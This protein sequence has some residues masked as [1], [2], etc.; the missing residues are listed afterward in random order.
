MSATFALRCAPLLFALT[1]FFLTLWRF[2]AN[3]TAIL[4]VVLVLAYR[5]WRQQLFSKCYLRQ[6]LFLAIYALI[7][8]A[9]LSVSYAHVPH[10]TTAFQGLSVYL[11]LLFL[12]V[13]P[14]A[15]QNQKNRYW[16]EE[17]LI[18][19]VLVNV[20]L[21]SLHYFHLPLPAILDPAF[22]AGLNKT[23]AINALQLI[24]VVAL[25]LW[26][27]AS[28]VL[29][30]E[31]KIYDWIFLIVL[32]LYLWFI[33]EERSGYL[34]FITLMAVAIVQ[35]LPRKKWLWALGSIPLLL[36]LMYGLSASVRHRVEMGFQNIEA[37]HAV[38]TVQSIGPDNSLGLR[39]AF[40]Q[41]S[42]Q[43]IK[44]HPLLGM[45]VGSFRQVYTTTFH[46]PVEVNDPHNAYIAV[47]FELGLVGLVLYVLWLA[48]L[49]KTI[50]RAPLELKRRL[51]G[52]WWA[53]VI[54]GFTD[55]GLVLNAV[56]VSTL[57]L[58]AV[59]MPLCNIGV[60]H[61]DHK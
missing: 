16:A 25:C 3:Q 35:Y 59:Y 55:S 56:A 15:V 7:A 23:F 50:G 41:E 46:N 37:F 36:L 17:G 2:G 20:S 27:L 22:H 29:A 19:G 58:L 30:R 34:L 61:R 24:F 52:I 60:H 26:I 51:Q 9:L 4:L 28:R 45:G 14:L 5:P 57:M 40:A 32:T 33:N 47:T 39:L 42:L 43:V 8:L 1:G 6:P 18:L 31:A 48:V 21:T 54:M 12:V 10:L 49:W 11:K 13:F 53:F 44:T 38:E